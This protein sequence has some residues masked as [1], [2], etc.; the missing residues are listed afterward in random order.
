MCVNFRVQ[1]VCPTDQVSTLFCPLRIFAGVHLLLPHARLALHVAA[2]AHLAVARQAGEAH[3]RVVAAAAA[4]ALAAGVLGARPAARARGV[5]RRP[6]EAGRVLQV[7]QVGGAQALAVAPGA[8]QLRLPGGGVGDAQHSHRRVVPVLQQPAR[9]VERRQLLPAGPHGAGAGDAVTLAG[10]LQTAL[11][12]L[13]WGKGV[14]GEG[15]GCQLLFDSLPLIWEIYLDR[16][17]QFPAGRVSEVRG[18]GGLRIVC[19]FSP[20][21]STILT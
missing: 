17:R 1:P 10:G 15:R 5:A 11:H 8:R 2:P 19:A 13:R 3:G 9:V 4:Q 6:A 18:G 21:Q 12:R 16:V 7:D 20:P 14:W